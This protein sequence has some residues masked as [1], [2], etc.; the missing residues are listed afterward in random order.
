MGPKR[1][2]R[3]YTDEEKH[4]VEYFRE[5]L[6]IRGVGQ[7]PRDWHLKQLSTARAMLAG[8]NAPTLEDWKACIDWAFTEPFWKDKL[9]HLA[10]IE[11]L[12]PRF[13]L[14]RKR[15]D[16]RPRKEIELIESLYS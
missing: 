13:A 5:A 15:A 11:A 4:L 16:T 14:Q 8:K 9:D 12:W 6:R 7:V 2:R 1:S 10:R 3:P